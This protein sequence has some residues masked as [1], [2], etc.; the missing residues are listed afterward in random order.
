MLGKQ[1]S[2]INAAFKDAPKRCTIGLMKTIADKFHRVIN[3]EYLLTG[4]GDMLAPDKRAR[5][6]ITS[7]TASAGFMDGISAPDFGAEMRV[8]EDYF[9]EYDLAIRVYG[10]SMEP[11]ISS[12]DTL[13]C[14][15]L[16]RGV[17]LMPDRVYLLDTPEGSV[18]KQILR[19]DDK[20]LLLHSF[21]PKYHDYEIPADAVLHIALVIMSIREY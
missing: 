17:P 7:Q 10:D 3:R 21:N 16:E 14:R 2:H 15:K 13:L 12:G 11:S 9:P 19:A 8:P 20:T 4:E 5:P 18:V 6:F 1:T